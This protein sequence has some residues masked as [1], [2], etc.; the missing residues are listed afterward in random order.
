M[1]DKGSGQ[2]SKGNG[3]HLPKDQ[4]Y[5]AKIDKLRPIIL[6]AEKRPWQIG[7][8]VVS[9][10][11]W[12]KKTY[13][14]SISLEQLALDL[15]IPKVGREYLNKLALTA[16]QFPTKFRRAD[17]TWFE[18]DDS[19]QVNTPPAGKTYTADDLQAIVKDRLAREAKKH[20]KELDALKG[21]YEKKA[22]AKPSANVEEDFKHKLAQHEA[23]KRELTEKLN[24]FQKNA[25]KA[26]LVSKL[27]TAGCIDPSDASEIILARNL[28]KF[29]DDRIVA[30]NISGDVDEFVADFLAKRPYL[31]K[32]NTQGGAGTKGPANPAVTN[33]PTDPKQMT[34]EQLRLAVG[35]P[36]TQTNKK[37]WGK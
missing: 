12:H 2:V 3:K 28:V 7:D 13:G 16:K 24:T 37:L 14:A 8:H 31:V 22:V 18:H 15:A 19:Q 5:K 10:Q 17:L 33:V 4:K 20:S 32:S 27:A 25:A 34:L 6:D 11:E 9:L 36:A 21:E 35:A 1:R 26:T 23:E 30:D 29:E